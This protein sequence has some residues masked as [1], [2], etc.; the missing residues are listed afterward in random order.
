MKGVLF[1]FVYKITNLTNQKIYIGITNDWKRRFREHKHNHAPSSLIAKAIQKYGE[2]NFSF[3]ILQ[4]GLS[5]EQACEKE[6]YFIE[7]FN[8]RA[9]NGYNVSKG[10][11]IH[12]GTSNG[13]SKLTEEEVQYIKDHRNL[14]MY[15]LYNDFCDKITYAA[16]KKIYKHQ[17]YIDIIP[18]V[19]QYPYN[20]EF[21][22]QFTSN[23]KL[24]YGEVVELRKAYANKIHWKEIYKKGYDKIYP[25][26]MDFWNIYNGNIYKLVM[27][28]VF[29]E[30]NKHFQASI[31]HSGES[32]GRSKLTIEDV[33][34]IRKMHEQDHLSNS[35]I[36]KKYPNLSQVSIRNVIN[37]KT[38]KN[39]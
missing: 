33:H 11:D 7:A 26:P 12:T 31:S 4:Q 25:R 24:D 30:E 13:M 18:H 21:S 36:Y 38:W 9:P 15:V 1:M 3:E 37:Y 29:T 32:N 28:E 39:L 27:P 34:A 6:I 35:D 23:N 17:T 20:L 19:E 22:N 2:N 16:F 14:P 8:C 5:I 10:G